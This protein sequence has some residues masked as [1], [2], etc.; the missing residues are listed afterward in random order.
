MRFHEFLTE[1][2]RVR[3]FYH[4]SDVDLPRGT[5]LTPASER[6]EQNRELGPAIHFVETLRPA[7]MLGHH[8]GV[9][10]ADNRDVIAD[11][12]GGP[13]LFTVKPLGK[14]RQHDINW[15]DNIGVLLQTDPDNSDE[16]RR[17]AQNYWLGVAH[18]DNET[19]WEYVT[20]RA[21]IIRDHRQTRWDEA[22]GK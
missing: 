21:K 22:D 7:E 11:T 10:M 9:F 3:R 18:P 19:M 17:V 2:P 12:V 13:Y 6:P 5:I 4:G 20:S 16:L 8:T 14:V 15:L 1:T